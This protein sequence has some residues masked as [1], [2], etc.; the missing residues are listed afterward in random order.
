[1][2]TW[3]GRMYGLIF[4]W[5]AIR[6]FYSYPLLGSQSYYDNP[7]PEWL[8]LGGLQLLFAAL[9]LFKPRPWQLFSAA[10]VLFL[11]CSAYPVGRHV[12]DSAFILLLIG[13]G[14]VQLGGDGWIPL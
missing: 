11:W 14:I 1:M 3:I 4:A 6:H 7:K 10:L 5:H 12:G 13:L 8:L 2:T 9:L